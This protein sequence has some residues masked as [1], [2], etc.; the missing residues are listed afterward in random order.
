MVTSHLLGT[1]RKLATAVLNSNLKKSKNNEDNLRLMDQVFKDQVAQG[2]IE[3]VDNLEQFINENPNHSFLAHMGVFKPDRETTKCRVVYLSNLCE[4]VK[5]KTVVSHNQAI[6]PGPC[7]NQKLTTSLLNLRFGSKLLC[8]DLKRAFN[9]L[10]LNELDSN[11][12]LCLWFRNVENNDFSIVAYRN[13][14]LSFGLRCSPTLLMLALFRIL[15][16]DAYNDPDNLRNL[17]SLIYQLSY[18]DNCAIS[19]ESSEYLQWA[20][21]QL[22]NIFE[23]YHFSLQQFIS[24]DKEIQNSIDSSLNCNTD[25]VVKLLGIMW[26]RDTDEISTRPIN[27]DVKA[28][29]KRTVL[30]SIAAQFDMYNFN[31]PLLNRARSFLHDLQCRSDIGWDDILEKEKLNDWKNIV[32]QANSSPVIKIPRFVG[33][34]NHSYRLICFADSSKS[35]FG[36]VVYI[37]NLDTNEINFVLSKNRI[38]NKSLE[39]KT[40]PS[41]ELQGVLLAVECLI[42]LYRELSG[43]SSIHP[44]NIK[45]LE[46]FSDSL[47][48]L[49]WVNSYAIK[50][51]KMQKRSTFVLNRLFKIQN[52]CKEFPVKFSFISGSQNPADLVTRNTSYKQLKKSNYITGPEFLKNKSCTVS[53]FTFTVPCPN[54][55]SKVPTVQVLE[56]TLTSPISSPVYEDILQ[57]SSTFSKLVGIYHKVLLFVNKLKS[58]IK[59]KNSESNFLIDDDSELFIKANRV[60]PL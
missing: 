60:D 50:Q 58:K 18:M 35:I 14:R 34:R 32:S 46:V 6:H 36:I 56:A 5:G 42:D 40:I 28:N 43:S 53:D 44:L 11:K 26:H 9:M 37:H 8:F 22:N 2:I 21:N 19:A 30:S 12:L 16:L 33:E 13:I 27:L 54:F 49:N 3:R 7:L 10:S 17:K 45:E 4:Q 24:N 31:G 57:K 41:L 52:L 20:F 29:S 25:N 48:S 47:V 59:T 15:I 23:P 55:D 1:N 38:V 51:D 39:S